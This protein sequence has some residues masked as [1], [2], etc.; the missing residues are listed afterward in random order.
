VGSYKTKRHGS[1]E[2][3]FRRHIGY[4]REHQFAT[5]ISLSNRFVLYADNLGARATPD[6]LSREALFG[7]I[8]PRG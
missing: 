3:T 8:R 6:L 5:F 1:D 4:D 7:R 2:K